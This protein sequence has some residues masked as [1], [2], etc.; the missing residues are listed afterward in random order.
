MTDA[1]DWLEQMKTD[2]AVLR[3]EVK[4]IRHEGK[5]TRKLIYAL[6]P[7]VGTLYLGVRVFDSWGLLHVP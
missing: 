6:F 7:L 4:W 1:D 3:N 5:F 2:L